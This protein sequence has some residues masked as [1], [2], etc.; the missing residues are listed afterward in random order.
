[1]RVLPTLTLAFSLG[2]ADYLDKPVEWSRLKRVLD[3][4]R[5]VG[6]DV[7]TC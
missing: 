7:E 4:F 3:R 5:A 1:M 6:V 2:A